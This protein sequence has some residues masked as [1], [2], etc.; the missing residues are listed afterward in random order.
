MAAAPKPAHRTDIRPRQSPM[1]PEVSYGQL[2][3]GS[4]PAHRHHR[5]H[6][7]KR[8]S[9]DGKRRYHDLSWIDSRI[10]EQSSLRSAKFNKSFHRATHRRRGRPGGRG[11]IG[12][13]RQRPLTPCV[14]VVV[15]P[16]GVPVSATRSANGDIW[17]STGVWVGTFETC[18]YRAMSEFREAK[19]KQ[20]RTDS[21]S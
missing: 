10:M 9:G 16:E 19:R 17:C 14:L 20:C 21:F 6:S 2:F 7:R 18:D 5:Q 12:K 1:R 3:E 4:R 15:A 8:P 13:R 11:R